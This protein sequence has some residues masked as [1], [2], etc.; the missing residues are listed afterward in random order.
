MTT[1]LSEVFKCTYTPSEY[2]N[3]YFEERLFD[4]SVW[5]FPVSDKAIDGIEIIETKY[6]LWK[7]VKKQDNIGRVYGTNDVQVNLLKED[8]QQNGVDSSCPPV[9]IDIDT[10]DIITGGHRHDACAHLNIPGWMFVY[11][12]CAS[13]WARKRFAKTLNNER[14]FHSKLNNKDE[15]IEHI[16]FGIAEG[17]LTTQTEIEE[18]VALIAN[19]SLTATVQGTIVKEMMSWIVSQ[20]NVS[21]KPN[22]YSSHNDKTFADFVARSTD[23]YVDDVMNNSADHGF[24]YYVNMENWN[25]R[26]NPLLTQ[27]ANVPI[28]KHLN[29]QASVGLPSK[30]EDLST[31]RNKVHNVYF[32]RLGV[33]CRKLFHYFVSNGC[34]PWEHKNCEHAYLAQ[35]ISEGVEEGKFIRH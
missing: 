17:K 1:T 28:D 20:N 26:T 13:P 6:G 16:K 5:T 21:V 10:G 12:R 31:K 14:V 2:A 34:L 8:I 22:R 24:N 4:P 30:V 23:E 35:E 25:S 33:D 19:N 3:D 32:N 15:V 29:I 11:V 9:F 18:E 7:D 27:A